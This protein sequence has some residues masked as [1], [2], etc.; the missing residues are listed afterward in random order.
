[1]DVVR[2]A[3]WFLSFAFYSHLLHVIDLFHGVSIVIKVLDT[4][5]LS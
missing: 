3:G 4:E 5:G 2:S 1:M